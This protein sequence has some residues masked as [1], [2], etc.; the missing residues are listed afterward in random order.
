M[1]VILRV[2]LAVVRSVDHFCW[3]RAKARI[4]EFPA[5]RNTTTGSSPSRYCPGG[6]PTLS[7]QNGSVDSLDARI[8]RGSAPERQMYSDQVGLMDTVYTLF[9]RQKIESLLLIFR[10]NR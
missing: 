8:G 1:T 6:L 10:R 7:M 9:G 5:T 3:I 2:D 4:C